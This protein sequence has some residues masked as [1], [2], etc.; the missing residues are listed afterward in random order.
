MSASRP[1]VFSGV[2][3]TSDSLHL[4]NALGAFVGGLAITAGLGYTS[5]LWVGA[6]ITAAAVVV[7]AFAAVDARRATRRMVE[8]RA[9]AATPTR[10]TPAVA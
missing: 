10:P 3:P 2:Q 9:S 1:V 4:G 6:V 8:V 7:M 5:P